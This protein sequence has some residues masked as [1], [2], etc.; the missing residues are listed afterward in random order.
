VVVSMVP[1]LYQT[2][3]RPFNEEVDFFDFQMRSSQVQ[4]P[5]TQVKKCQNGSDGDFSSDDNAGGSGTIDGAIDFGTNN[6]ARGFTATKVQK[7]LLEVEAPMTLLLLGDGSSVDDGAGARRR[8][9]AAR[10]AMMEIFLS[11]QWRNWHWR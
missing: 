3:S 7:T 8:W 1:F 11:W 4:V 2:S 5:D 10:V 9:W 6:G